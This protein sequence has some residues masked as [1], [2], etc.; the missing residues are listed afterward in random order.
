[1]PNEAAPACSVAF[2]GEASTPRV[3]K[4]FAKSTVGPWI[5]AF[6]PPT[7][8]I[9]ATFFPARSAALAIVSAWRI[10]A[11]ENEVELLKLLSPVRWNV[12]FVEP[13][14][15]GYVPVAIVYQPTPVFGGK[16]W[17]IPFCPS[18][19]AARSAAYVGI[20]PASAYFA[21][22]SGRMP[23]DEYSKAF[24]ALPTPVACFAAPAPCEPIT[25]TSTALTAATTAGTNERSSSPPSPRLEKPLEKLYRVGPLA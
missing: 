7:Q 10:P 14:S 15:P 8:S 25:S 18:T 19:P 9:W 12:L 2:T 21:I 11:A 24:E 22:R 6:R 20:A 3:E 17:V 1:M 23:S 5:P 16:A 4:K 13:C